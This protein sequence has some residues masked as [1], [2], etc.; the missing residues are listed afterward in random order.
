MGE[1][2]RIR[3][4]HDRWI[5]DNTLKDLY[6]E[7]Y[8]CSAAN[9]ACISEVLWIPKEG[10]VRVWDLRFY[11]VFK[12]WELAASY[13]L[14]QFIQTS[15]PWGDRRDTLWWRLKG[16]GKFD[17]RSYYHAIRDT[18]NSLFP[19]KGVWKPKIPKRV[20][21][22][23]WTAAYDRT[24]TLDNL[25]LKGC[26][27]ANQCCMCCCEGESMD[28]PLLPCPVTHTLWTFM[29]QAFGIH[30]VMPR[31]VAGLLSCWHRWLGKHNSNIWNLVP[32]CLMWTVWL[33]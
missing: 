23:L 18:P 24:L 26:P 29:L 32:G 15:I 30:C 13:S 10:T 28:H 19:W 8:V 12:D 5:G 25:M 9:D 33:K 16:D 14:L 31:T 1:G 27:L 3:F 22:S 4:W 17:T 20:A 2:T 11:R 6:P 21:F 7:L